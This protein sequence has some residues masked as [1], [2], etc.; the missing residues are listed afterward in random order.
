MFKFFN[1]FIYYVEN[2]KISIQ[3]ILISVLVIASIRNIFELLYKFGYIFPKP[4]F[5]STYLTFN[6]LF[7]HFNSFWLA[8]FISLT[9]VLYLFTAKNNSIKNVLKFSMFGMF[10]I[11]FP[12]LFDFLI[13]NK[14][15]ML[16]PNNPTDLFMN[17]KHYFC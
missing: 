6:G 5:V 9:V 3:G 16:Y 4:N 2:K 12:V 14:D 17:L 11:I 7:V 10:I 1:N 13:G 8:V 15:M